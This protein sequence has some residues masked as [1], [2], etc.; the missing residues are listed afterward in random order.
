MGNTNSVPSTSNRQLPEIN[1]RVLI[2]GRANAGKTS[3]LQRVCDTTDSPVVYRGDEEHDIED[4]LRFSYHD[5]YI[6]HDSRVFEAG[7]DKEV[8]IVQEFI[9][10]RSGRRQLR[11]RIHAIWY[12]VPMDNQRPE[13]DL[14]H[15]KDICPDQ[16]VPVIA[17]FAEYDQFIRN[18]TMHLEDYGNP[19]DA[20]ESQFREHYHVYLGGGAKFVQLERM[21]K[22]ETRCDALLQ[23]TVK[24]L[25]A[26][27]VGLMFLAVQ[28]GSLEICVNIAVKRADIE[29]SRRKTRDVVRRCLYAFP[30]IWA[31]DGKSL[32]CW[33]YLN[34]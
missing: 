24:A 33:H 10:E 4:E 32:L 12:C 15:F 11:D 14:K 9:Q 26:D 18:V 30:Q 13:L 1:F 28:R 34:P 23:E 27:V 3:I 31:M 20:V 17:V 21:H 16:N 6:F 29:L 19:D 2:I 7:C 25:H 8:K 5:G 22:T